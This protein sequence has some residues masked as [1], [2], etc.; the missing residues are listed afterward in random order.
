MAKEN[1]VFL[2]GQVYDTPKV[3]VDGDGVAKKASFAVK[4]LRRPTS[5]GE[6]TVMTGKLSVDIPIIMTMDTALIQLCATLH[7]GD[8]VDIRG[9]YTTR[10]VKKKSTCPNGHESA[11][12]GNFVFIT[13]LYIC[14]HERELSD[15]DGLELLRKRSEVSNLVMLMG[16]LCR[17]PELREFDSGSSRKATVCQ[18]QLAANRRYHIKDGI[19]DHERTDY[20]WIKTAGKQAIEDAERLRTGSTVYI[21]GAIQTREIE[22]KIVCP[23]CGE[24]Y[25]IKESVCEIFPYSVEYLMNC[26]FPEKEED[27][28]E[29]SQEEQ[30]SA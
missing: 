9:V 15:E 21:N 6:G 10:E 29:A 24:E 11:W 1:F 12:A 20:P 27:K 26:L 30:P 8:M 14:P 7:K 16:T 19:H 18:Y 3:Y 5:R 4:V 13:P 2:H 28:G 25:T 23:E 22:R 17:D